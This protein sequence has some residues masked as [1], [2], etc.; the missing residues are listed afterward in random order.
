MDWN[1]SVPSPSPYM[2]QLIKKIEVLLSQ[3]KPILPE[4]QI[5]VGNVVVDLGIDDFLSDSLGTI[6]VFRFSVRDYRSA[7]H[8]ACRTRKVK[9]QYLM[10]CRIMGDIECLLGVF[11]GIP[12]ILERGLTLENAFRD[13]YAKTQEEKEKGKE[14][15][16][17]WCVCWTFVVYLSWFD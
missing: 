7:E 4:D 5:Q 16:K 1:E 8:F 9:E 13:R 15:G 2:D 11:R 10:N 17:S 3:L 12:G 6:F 14:E